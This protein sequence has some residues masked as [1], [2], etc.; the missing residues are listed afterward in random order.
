MTDS[1]TTYV[2]ATIPL[3]G[4][5]VPAGLFATLTDGALR[6]AGIIV[7]VILIAAIGALIGSQITMHRVRE[8]AVDR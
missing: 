7:L 2:A 6:I 1:D 3:V 8:E 4:A 5:L